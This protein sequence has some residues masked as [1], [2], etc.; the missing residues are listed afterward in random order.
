MTS[1]TLGYQTRGPAA[2]IALPERAEAGIVFALRSRSERALCRPP[3]D[4]GR[5]PRVDHIDTPTLAELC[6]ALREISAHGHR[7]ALDGSRAT[8]RQ[9][10]RR[11]LLARPRSNLSRAS[12]R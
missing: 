3:L 12:G 8:Q 9:G 2:G 5:S 7:L 11:H 6:V 4:R 1:R 10:G